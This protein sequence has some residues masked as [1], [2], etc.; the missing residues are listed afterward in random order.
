MTRSI[1]V[2]L[3]ALFSTH[4]ALAD[5]PVLTASRDRWDG[6]ELV[7]TPASHGFG[8]LYRTMDP[9]SCLTAGRTLQHG[10]N[11]RI[12]RITPGLYLPG[13]DRYSDELAPVGVSL[14]Y[15]Y[16]ESNT[17]ISSAWGYRQA[18]PRP[19]EVE[20]FTATEGS[21]PEHVLLK[22]NA[23]PAAQGYYLW[24][25]TDEGELGTFLTTVSGTRQHLDR[26]VSGTT[27]Y[28]Y[29]IAAFNSTG[30]GD[31][32]AQVVGYA[33]GKDEVRL[34][35]FRA[36]PQVEVL[37]DYRIEVLLQNTGT[38]V[39]RKGEYFLEI[40]APP[41][42]PAMRLEMAEEPV[43]PNATATLI[44]YVRAP[45]MPGAYSLSPVF[46]RQTS[47]DRPDWQFALP[48]FQVQVLPP[49]P[50]SPVRPPRR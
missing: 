42:W 47:T 32:T 5:A 11:S 25:S 27:A 30:V 31:A 34:A 39:W 19:T 3:L 44:Y 14:C 15:M 41:A 36:E 35:L 33:G 20:Q 6:I 22:W 23:H 21:F 48:S 49:Q 7:Q 17:V 4:A 26:T 40:V 24:R 9:G 28:Y 1:L 50:G 2:S 12:E 37:A 16:V 43:A 10:S 38:S 29:T 13:M 18:L 8:D 45:S 46:K